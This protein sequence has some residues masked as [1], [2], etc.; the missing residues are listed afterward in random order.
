MADVSAQAPRLQAGQATTVSFSLRIPAIVPLLLVG[1]GIRLAL[2]FIDGFRVDMGTFQAWSTQLANDHPWNFYKPG[3]FADYA[4]GYMYVLWFIGEIHQAV[5][6]TNEQY[7]Y[8]L[9]IPSIVADLGS[10]W[11]LWVMLKEQ[12]AWKRHAVPALYLLLPPVLWIGAIWG[13]VDSML[14]FFLLLSVYY[15]GK[16]RPVAG[17]VAYTIGFLVKPQAIAALPILA[18]WIMR[19]YPATPRSVSQ[20]VRLASFSALG[21]VSTGFLAAVFGLS[22]PNWAF[23][24]VTGAIFGWAPLLI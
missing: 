9:K 10:A 12:P 21:I 6:F 13:Q 5:T 1:L 4:P 19:K 17:A 18:F 3:F 23:A 22:A 15:I 16:D 7:Q 8:A 14:S 2:A 24:V 20:R 11:L